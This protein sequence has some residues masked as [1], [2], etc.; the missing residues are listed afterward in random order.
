MIKYIFLCISL[1]FLTTNLYSKKVYHFVS[2]ENIII[3]EVGRIV[4]PEIFKKLN[5]E[6]TVTPLPAKRAELEVFMGRKDGEVMRIGSY[7]KSNPNTIRVPTSYYSFGTT[8]F[9]RKDSGIVIDKIEDLKKYRIVKQ[10]GVKHTNDVTAGMPNVTSLKTKEA[11]MLFLQRKRA[12][13]VLTS[14]I[15]GDFTLKKLNIKNIVKIKKPLS[16]F[17][18]YIYMYK[19]HK[20]IVPEV[21][22]II[23][24]MIANGELEELVKE[25]EKEVLKSYLNK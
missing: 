17:E 11:M 1:L 7:I 18:I 25:A 23:K 4:V 10:V 14:A 9:V 8:A 16:R 22:S 20:E 12:D 13:I 19:D 6:T 5:I 15:D 24:Q 3:E 2:M 21:D